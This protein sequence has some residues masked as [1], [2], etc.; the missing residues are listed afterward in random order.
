MD[1]PISDLCALQRRRANTDETQGPP[2][3]PFH[4]IVDSCDEAGRGASQEF[5]HSA[6][7]GAP[8]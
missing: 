4:A 2:N 3:N 8:A 7:F 6:E 1:M 5:A